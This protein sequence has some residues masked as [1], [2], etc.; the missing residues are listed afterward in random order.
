MYHCNTNNG[1]ERLNEELKYEELER[2][3]RSLLS[4]LLSIIIEK[5]IPKL[6]VK[7]VEL[8][9]RC[10]SGYKGYQEGI[11]SYLHNRPKSLVKH[12]LLLNNFVTTLMIYKVK[13]ANGEGVCNSEMDLDERES[14]KILSAIIST[15]EKRFS[16]RSSSVYSSSV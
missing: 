2:A 7:Y 5:V 3:T 11:P 16:V 10:T 8:N 6:Y 4:G 13:P 9:L 15:I 12:L 1:T 14:R